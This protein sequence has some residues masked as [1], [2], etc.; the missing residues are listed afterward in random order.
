MTTTIDVDKA[1]QMLADGSMKMGTVA[2][3]L[4]VELVTLR[5]HIDPDY[6]AKHNVAN[7]DRARVKAEKVKAKEVMP[8]HGPAPP[9]Q[10]PPEDQAARLAEIPKTDTRDLTGRVMG[11][12]LSGRSALDR[13]FR[14]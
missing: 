2:R 13:R 10:P 14:A 1:K 11:D 3:L 9:R 8:K 4:G 7:R 12:P 5:R 6:R